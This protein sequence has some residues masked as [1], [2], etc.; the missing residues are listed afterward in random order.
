MSTALTLSDCVFIQDV[1]LMVLSY[2]LYL[3]ATLFCQTSLQLQSFFFFRFTDSIRQA[4][5]SAEHTGEKHTGR[6]QAIHAHEPRECS[7]HTPIYNSAVGRLI[8]VK[9][10]VLV[11]ALGHRGRGRGAVMAR[12]HHG[13]GDQIGRLLPDGSQHHDLVAHAEGRLH[14]GRDREGAAVHQVPSAEHLIP[15]V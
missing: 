9:S 8:T 13:A 3:S 12:P 14:R 6:R 1:N 5:K 7:F 2:F 4:S 10:V 15:S 11:Y